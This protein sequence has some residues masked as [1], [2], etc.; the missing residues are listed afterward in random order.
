MPPKK[1]GRPP[2]IDARPTQPPAK[3]VRVG[4]T[5]IIGTQDSS[6][7]TEPSRPRRV[8]AGEPNYSSKRA[9]APNGEKA[10]AKASASNSLISTADKASERYKKKGASTSFGKRQVSATAR[11]EAET[12]ETPKRGRGRPKK[13]PAMA[14]VA[15][16]KKVS[17]ASK[18]F[19]SQPSSI[20]KRPVG[21]P[22][23]TL[24]DIKSVIAPALKRK[25]PATSVNHEGDEDEEEDLDTLSNGPADDDGEEGTE[26][27]DPGRHYWLM[28][29]EPNSR[30]VRG[31]DVKFSIDDL[32]AKA[33]PEA[34]DGVRNYGAR[35]NMRLMR[36][37]DLAFFYHSSCEVPGIAGIMEIVGEHTVDGIVFSTTNYRL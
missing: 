6:E 8:S 22:K 14:D 18:R 21:R 13:V 12:S 7:A 16:E 26:D 27:P 11:A 19:V 5:S 37:G 31:V 9:R 30:I 4:E 33:K 24:K 1:R 25:G 34:W 35:N 15:V 20:S 2:G 32:A 10:G 29:A 23:K 3:R 17:T 36:A 28:K